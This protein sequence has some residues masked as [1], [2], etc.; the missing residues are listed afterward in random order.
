MSHLISLLLKKEGSVKHCVSC[1]KCKHTTQ[2]ENDM[3]QHKNKKDGYYSEK[4]HFFSTLELK[5][6]NF[7]TGPN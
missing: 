7:K 3:K 1:D 4:C 2:T 6:T 5:Y